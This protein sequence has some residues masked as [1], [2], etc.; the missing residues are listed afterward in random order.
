VGAGTFANDLCAI[1]A[2]GK[3]EEVIKETLAWEVAPAV[4]EY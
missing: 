3:G 1:S 4:M 2:T